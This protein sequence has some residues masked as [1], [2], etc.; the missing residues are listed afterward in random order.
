MNKIIKVRCKRI[1]EYATN[2][3]NDQGKTQLKNPSKKFDKNYLNLVHQTSD[4][5]KRSIMLKLIIFIQHKTM[6][7]TFQKGITDHD[8]ISQ[9]CE[10]CSMSSL[11]QPS[12]IK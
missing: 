12:C 9:K 6:I 11:V 10:E 2:Y 5:V 8:Y 3:L 4:V 1:K 7:T